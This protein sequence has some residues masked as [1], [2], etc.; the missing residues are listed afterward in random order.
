MTELEKT[1]SETL[2]QALVGR[3]HYVNV[4]HVLEGMH[5]MTAGDRPSRARHSVFRV[6]NHMSFWQNLA[7]TGLRGE[8]KPP[9]PNPE[10]GW[11]GRE[12]PGNRED[13][14]KAI[15]RFR[16]GLEGMI[17]QARAG[18]LERVVDPSRG[19]TA[20]AAIQMVAQHNA[21]HVGQIVLLRRQLAAWPP[22]QPLTEFPQAG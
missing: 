9:P 19:T 10:Q 15:A 12:E 22:P 14:E 13:W 1:V 6:L 8:Q 18:N 3:S 20:F 2:V 21:Y 5:W 7:L 11:P 17:E 4:L 16:T